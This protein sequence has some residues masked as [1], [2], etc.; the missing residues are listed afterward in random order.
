MLPGPRQV[1]EVLIGANGL[2]DGM[3]A[4]SIW[5]DMSTSEQAVANRVRALAQPRGIE[6]LDAPVS[7]MAAGARAG[8]LQIFVGG[9]ADSY[10]R[11]RPVLEAM[12]DPDRILHVGGNGPATQSS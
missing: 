4:G 5:A 2:L 1:E 10:Q 9:S 12:G 7:G 8:T 3:P 6:V 11:V